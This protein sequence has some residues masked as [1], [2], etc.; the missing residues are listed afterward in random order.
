MNP[1]ILVIKIQGVSKGIGVLKRYTIGLLPTILK[2]QNPQQMYIL[3]Q[4]KRNDMK[5]RAGTNLSI[6]SKSS[7]TR[8]LFRLISGLP[9]FNYRTSLRHQT[10]VSE[11]REG[12][13]SVTTQKVG[14]VTKTLRTNNNNN[15][16]NF[17]DHFITGLLT[18]IGNEI[19]YSFRL[20]TGGN[21]IKMV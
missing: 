8:S 3:F 15:N 20:F 9:F 11:F 1:P 17:K 2:I 12:W 19:I 16:Y 4:V 10:P 5:C 6:S 13:I 18:N 21:T 14:R 7:K